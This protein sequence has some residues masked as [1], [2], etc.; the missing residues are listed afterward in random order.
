MAQQREIIIWIN[1]EN[2]ALRFYGINT[3]RRNKVHVVNFFVETKKKQTYVC[4]NVIKG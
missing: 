2:V 1:Y 4:I 3:K